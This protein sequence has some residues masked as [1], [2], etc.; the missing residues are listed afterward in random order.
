MT[1]AGARPLPWSGE[2][3]FSKGLDKQKE[4]KS[5]RALGRA[6]LMFVVAHFVAVSIAVLLFAA[7]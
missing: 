5:A 1:A 6:C 3:G 2:R 7:G 4:G